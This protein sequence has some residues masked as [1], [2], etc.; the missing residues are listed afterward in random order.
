VRFMRWDGQR[1]KVVTDWMVPMPEDRK[2]VQQKYIE[3]A[4]QY[5]NE[6]GIKPRRC[7]S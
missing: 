7:P 6:K 5:A 2:L 3:S 1:W 4:M